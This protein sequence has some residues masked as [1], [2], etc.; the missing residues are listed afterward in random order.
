MAVFVQFAA[1][2]GAEFCRARCSIRCTRTAHIRDGK[3]V[4]PAFRRS[5]RTVDGASSHRAHIW[6]CKG[7][8]ALAAELIIDGNHIFHQQH[9]II[10]SS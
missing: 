5:S 1:A 6:R 8:T 10:A 9:S 2:D 4:H 3:A 7:I